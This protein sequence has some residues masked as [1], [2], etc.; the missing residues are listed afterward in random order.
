MGEYAKRKSDGVEI[1]IGTCESMY[2]L[3]WDDRDKVTPLPGSLNPATEG[4][5]YWRLPLPE[6]DDILP[7]AYESHDKR[8]TLL[9]WE[10]EDNSWKTYEPDDEVEP[11][12]FQLH[13]E[14]SGLLLNVR[15]YHGVKLPDVGADIKAFWNGKAY[16][17]W[18]LCF[19]KNHEL[20]DGQQEL[21]PLVRCRHCGSMFREQ[22]VNVLPHVQNKA[23]RDQLFTYAHSNF[24]SSNHVSH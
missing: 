16:H 21:R 12:T 7:G 13:H 1:K 23:L 24:S 22:W 17:N 15:C 19:I 9:P 20:P 5:L 6:E 18:E 11:G 4:N 14:S 2:Y 8:I 10:E 3:R